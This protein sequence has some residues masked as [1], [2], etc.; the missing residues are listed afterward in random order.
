MSVDL[1]FPE[2]ANYEI[3]E[4]IGQGGMGIVYKARQRNT[5][6]VVAL[7][8][9]LTG[10]LAGEK[11]VR[12]FRAEA[13]A[14]A[15][16]RH[17]NIVTLFEIG[18]ENGQHF[19]SMEYV[20][21]ESL[22]QRVRAKTLNFGEAAILVKKVAE[23]VNAAHEKGIL[24]RDLKP[25]NILIDKKGEPRITDFGL[26]QQQELKPDLTR[27]GTILGTPSYMPP[28]QALGKVRE[29]SV[30]SDVYSVGATLYEAITGRP[31]FQADS[32]L[33]TLTQVV[34]IPPAAPR[35]LNPKIPK[36]LEVICLKC[37]RKQ[38]LQRYASA[39][40]LAD[41]LGR[42]LRKE[43][44]EARPMGIFE[45]NVAW[46]LRNPALATALATAALLVALLAVAAF[47][48]RENLKQNN[49]VIAERS[50]RLLESYLLEVSEPVTKVAR[51]RTFAAWLKAPAQT[52]AI[53][54]FLEAETR[55]VVLQ[56]GLQEVFANWVALDPDGDMILRV[57]N[58]PSSV[59]RS[60]EQI[61]NPIG[62]TNRSPRDYFLGAMEKFSGTNEPR[63]H[64]SKVYKSVDDDFS[65]IGISCA[66]ADPENPMRVAGV[67]SIMLKT[68]STE[69]K[70][71]GF[72]DKNVKTA[73]LARWDQSAIN[74][75]GQ[76]P[77][78]V[79]W[80]HP[81]FQPGADA[82]P[83]K[84]DLNVE[85]RGNFLTYF[86][87]ARKVYT[88]YRGPWLAGLKPVPNTPFVV[89]VQ[90]RDWI[91]LFL[92]V[93]LF[94]VVAAGAVMFMFTTQRRRRAKKLPPL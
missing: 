65:K 14:V 79:V 58:G 20:E 56:P 47:L 48:F 30:C 73:I 55:K 44:I 68:F 50:A 62:L 25:A 81:G 24:H 3:L 36:D 23:A 93:A 34:E 35:L 19:F 45:R 10:S 39:A 1:P 52:N 54:E 63:V 71:L 18:H 5:E 53:A 31:P 41:D 51:N 32:A 29:L 72:G 12:R 21:G 46:C 6:R 37:L 94:C 74:K 15:K 78:W 7:K 9:I 43:P 42:F 90:S 80:L 28:E 70:R 67:V 17:Q 8:V 11:E 84:E 77:K 2:L 40:A 33:E 85:G 75:L 69:D 49:V 61:P 89:V 26:A 22:L 13:Q 16:L 87:P 83:V 88:A 60:P 92:G 64:F 59:V 82:I 76:I 66:I 27:S 86:D 4:E 57:T 91:L 38:P